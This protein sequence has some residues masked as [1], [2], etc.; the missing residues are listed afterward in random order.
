MVVGLFSLKH[1]PHFE[2]LLFASATVPTAKASGTAT[3]LCRGNMNFAIISLYLISGISEVPAERH[4]RSPA[5]F[6]APKNRKFTARTS[7]EF[8]ADLECLRV[9]R[10]A[11]SLTAAR[12]GSQ[13]QICVSRIL[14][15]H[16]AIF[17]TSGGRKWFPPQ[18][19]KTEF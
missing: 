9:L 16:I 13:P 8:A 19:H 4:K 15:H 18:T 5:I 3:R 11:M 1:C 6:L 17:N 2:V 10:T 14:R 12:T 7:V